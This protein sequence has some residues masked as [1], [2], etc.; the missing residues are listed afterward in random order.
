MSGGDNTHLYSAGWGMGSAQ[1]MRMRV[2]WIENP[3]S[4]LIHAGK[5]LKAYPESRGRVLSLSRKQSFSWGE[6]WDLSKEIQETTLE[7]KPANYHAFCAGV[8]LGWANWTLEAIH[9]DGS[10]F[11][12]DS[13]DLIDWLGNVSDHVSEIDPEAADEIRSRVRK[14]KGKVRAAGSPSGLAGAAAHLKGEI[15]SLKGDLISHVGH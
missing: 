15:S 9:R 3:E 14:T 4:E 8:N 10:A 11:D 1:L 5:W 7:T 6:V 13:D 2:H 12:R